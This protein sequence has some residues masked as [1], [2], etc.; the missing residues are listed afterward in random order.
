MYYNT[1]YMNLEPITQNDMLKDPNR[2]VK[3]YQR[4]RGDDIP[5]QYIF[6]GNPTDLKPAANHWEQVV[7]GQTGP[8]VEFVPFILEGTPPEIQDGAEI[9]IPPGT[10]T[11]FQM[12]M[13]ETEFS[14]VPLKGKLIFL[15]VGPEGK[16]SMHYF[17]VSEDHNSQ[18]KG[19]VRQGWIMCWYA[20]KNQDNAYVLEHEKPGFASANLA[21]IGK[22]VTSFNGTPMPE[23]WATI[24]ALENGQEAEVLQNLSHHRRNLPD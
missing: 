3:N 7:P 5:Q 2:R 17:D 19:F 21:T 24:E 12:V 20:C 6:N 16:F 11:P 15:S 13:S 10:H 18:Y 22:G 23:F 9:R 14:E 4:I 1:S 8:S